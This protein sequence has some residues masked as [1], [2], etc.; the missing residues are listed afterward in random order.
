MVFPSFLVQLVTTIVRGAPPILGI[1]DAII[2][3]NQVD[4]SLFVIESGKTRKAANRNAIRRLRQSGTAP[5]G[6]ILTKLG[7]NM[8]MYGYEADF[9]YYGNKE[10]LASGSKT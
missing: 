3:C 9:Y 6:A 4:A 10:A 5:L 2:L 1:A 7:G 8:T